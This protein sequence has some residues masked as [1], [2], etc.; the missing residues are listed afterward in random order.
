MPQGP[1]FKERYSIGPTKNGSIFCGNLYKKNPANGAI[2]TTTPLYASYSDSIEKVERTWDVNNPGP[3]FL[4]GSTFLNIKAEL[5][6]FTLE[7]TG[8]KKGP[9]GSP[10]PFVYYEYDGGFANPSFNVDNITSAQYRVLGN[11][12]L[13]AALQMPTVA[14]S[15]S[16]V[17]ARLKPK[18][19]HA[20]LAVALLESRDMP[21]MLK[22]TARG[23]HD[24][25]SLMGGGIKGSR[26]SGMKPKNLA[27]QFL[28]HQ[29]GWRPFLND[30]RQIHDTYQNSKKYI[31]EITRNNNTWVRRAR[32]ISHV[33]SEVRV[34]RNAGLWF[35]PWHSNMNS[36][37]TPV[38]IPGLGSVSQYV[39][40]FEQFTTREWA[41]GSFKFYRPEF[42]RSLSSYDTD[43]YTMQRY[44]KL[45][46][47]QCNPSTIWKATP[48]SW[49]IDWFS[50]VGDLVQRVTDVADDQ[51]AS[52]YM[53]LMQHHVRKFTARGQ[54]FFTDGATNLEWSRIAEIK[55]RSRAY[56]P[57]NFCLAW[58]D[59]TPRQL[60]ILASLGISRRG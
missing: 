6:Q 17:Y 19:E 7:G 14:G 49:L 56:N 55:Q 26:F 37:C 23:F 10:T 16:K 51:V 39:D 41:V 40:Y 44:L 18:L 22:T 15:C 24:A 20:G 60:A 5:P 34:S 8:V 50:N 52:R 12:A 48:W 25:W 1:R 38:S 33:D 57:Y 30:L 29:F 35:E 47:M 21:G 53:Y 3:P 46:G 31:D 32:T 13:P 27:D 2:V 54:I 36:M 59:T 45:Y 58:K 11:T 9:V 42:D 4:D 28:N 43:W